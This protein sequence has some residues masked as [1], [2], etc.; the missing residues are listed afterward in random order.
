[1]KNNIYKIVKQG[2]VKIG[3]A[4]IV[5][6]SPN[7]VCI[8]IDLGTKYAEFSATMFDDH[9]NSLGIMDI[10]ASEDSTNLYEGKDF[11]TEIAFPSYDG[12]RCFSKEISRYSMHLCFVKETEEF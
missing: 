6:E 11:P 8:K 1:M 7:I 2:E 9:T 3:H 10:V 12:F 4:Y 5:A